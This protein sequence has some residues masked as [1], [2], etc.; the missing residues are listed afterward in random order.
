MI[1]KPCDENKLTSSNREM[2]YIN[3]ARAGT[4]PAP[5]IKVDS[6]NS[7]LVKMRD[8]INLLHEALSELE[9]K[10]SCICIPSKNCS[11]SDQVTGGGSEMQAFLID[12]N[13]RLDLL[14]NRIDCICGSI[15]L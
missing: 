8:K 10:T 15:D 2:D 9:Q 7:Q 4:R 13:N 12:Q 6:I 1:S 14:M 11:A 5:E 3:S